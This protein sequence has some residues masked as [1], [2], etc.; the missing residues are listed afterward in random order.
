MLMVIASPPQLQTKTR[1]AAALLRQEEVATSAAG[2]CD[3]DSS[4]SDATAE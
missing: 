2:A 3:F 4:G 1:Q